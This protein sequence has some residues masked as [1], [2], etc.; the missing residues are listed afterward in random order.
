V[1]ARIESSV[2]EQL[3]HSALLTDLYELTM[4]AAYFESGRRPV[5]TFELFVRRL[6][7]NRSSLLTA[8]L[9]QALYY[10]EN[11]RFTP[12]EIDF[13]RHQPVFG[14]VSAPFFDYL[15]EFRFTGEV[16]AMAEG[17]PA[18]AQEPLLRVTA[19]IIEAQV[20]ETF[21]LTILTFQTMIAAKAARVVEAAQGRAVVEFGTRR[22]HGPE[23]GV[24]AARAAYI[25]GCAGTSNVEAGFRFG[26]PTFGTLAHS[27]VMAFD[28]ELES[29]RE[30]ERIFPNH[31]VLLVDTYDTMAAIERII[32]AGLRPRGV[33]LDSG[34]L[35]ELSKQARQRLDQAGLKDTKIFA[36]GDLNEYLIAELVALGTPIDMFGVGTEL[37]TSKD[38]PALS[39]VYKL[40]EIIEGGEHSYR[41]KLSRDKVTYPGAK[42]VFRFLRDGQFARDVIA[43]QGERYA[44]A[45]ALL[46]CVMRN[47][48]RLAASPPI[49][50]L[51][52]RAREQL[53]RLPDRY[54]RLRNAETYPVG[55]S[56]ELQR[57]EEAERQKHTRL[58]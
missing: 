58:E 52:Q 51:Q 43:C 37:A 14:H 45:E 50:Q 30:M 33:R 36:S 15:H 41:V 16:W 46:E 29:F 26:V 20:V 40:V 49:H 55:V 48:R 4:A 38:A 27:F 42:Q 24:L 2:P 7:E 34:N 9:E 56:E 10:L 21:L 28:D 44:G 54:R 31:S 23:A 8:G 1:S 22:A 25:G 53:H 35:A 3:C 5:A 6:P 11:L 18:F 32:A 47:G 17:T 13:L 57:L 19:P 39:G 12:E